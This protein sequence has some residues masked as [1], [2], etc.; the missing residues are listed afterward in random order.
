MARRTLSDRIRLRRQANDLLSVWTTADRPRADKNLGARIS[1][2]RRRSGLTQSELAGKLGVSQGTIWNWESERVVPDDA[3]IAQLESIL[4]SGISGDGG[5]DPVVNGPS[6]VGAWLSKA[7]QTRGVTVPE[8]A[9]KTGVSVPGIYNIES[10][11]AQSPR[12]STIT[13]LERALGEQFEHAAEEEL[14]QENQIE[15]LGAFADFDPH[16]E[17]DWPNEAG[18]RTSHR[19]SERTKRSSGSSSRSSNM[20]RMCRC[21]TRNCAIESSQPISRQNWRGLTCP[22]SVIVVLPLRPCAGQNAKSSPVQRALIKDGSRKR[23]RHLPGSR[24]V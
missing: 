12:Q 2:S 16:D 8:L 23:W 5:G 3:R 15:G 9:R 4:G 11:K 21:R 17:V 6:I 1:L 22:L 14:K 13:K 10:G 7:R 24:E 19:E 20:H 18:R